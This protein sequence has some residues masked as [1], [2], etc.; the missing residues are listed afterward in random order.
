MSEHFALGQG[1][2][3]VRAIVPQRVQVAFGVHDADGLAFDF[4]PEG[5]ARRNVDQ[6]GDPGESFHAQA[7]FAVIASR[8]SSTTSGIGSR[9][10][11]SPKKPKTTSRS[12]WSRG[13]PRA[14]R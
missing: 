6:G 14:M 2:I 3:L 4:D 5:R 12:A 9:A 11:T 8:S 13:M 7:I 1:E 10:S